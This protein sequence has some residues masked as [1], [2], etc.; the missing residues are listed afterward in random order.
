MKKT[1]EYYPSEIIDMAKENAIDMKK[2]GESVREVV[3]GH[4][5]GS[6]F[7]SD[8]PGKVVSIK[9]MEVEGTTF[10][11]AMYKRQ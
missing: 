1:E 2:K 7:L 9:T 5:S 8:D 4:K 3:F 10:H 6:F 11:I